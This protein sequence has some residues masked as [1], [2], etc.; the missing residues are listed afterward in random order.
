MNELVK[1]TLR[2]IEKQN[3]EIK[4]I[5]L[6]NPNEKK[7]TDF[8]TILALFINITLTIQLFEMLEK[9]V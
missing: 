8:G 2:L 7:F 1:N 3:I 5:D 6:W 9:K 4:Y